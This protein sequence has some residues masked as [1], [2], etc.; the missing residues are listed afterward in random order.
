M[1]DILKINKAEL[2]KTVLNDI[3]EYKYRNTRYNLDF[4]IVAVYCKEACVNLE[5]L[6]KKLRK[7]DKVIY[8][9]DN[10]C[11][12]ILDGVSEKECEKAAENVNYHLLQIN[13]N[14]KYYLS[15][16]D[17]KNYNSEYR[18]MIQNLF[19]RL[20]YAIENNLE[21]IV[22]YQDYVI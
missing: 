14:Y 16:A 7:T 10:L 13:A 12:V 9:N 8:L 11:C 17:S 18:D 3:K 21:N 1:S 5:E 2:F 22:I 19:E 20:E 15:A 4:S 6:Q